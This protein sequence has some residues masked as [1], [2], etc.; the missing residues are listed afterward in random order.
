M[1]FADI[2]NLLLGVAWTLFGVAS[3]PK[4]RP[5]QPPSYPLAVRNPYLSTWMPGNH[6]A[7]LPS[8]SP[9]FWAGQDL[10]WGIIVRV[11]GVAYNVFGVPKGVKGTKAGVIKGATYTSTHSIFELTAGAVNVKLDFFSPVSPSNY[12]RQSL[13]FSKSLISSSKN[14]LI[15]FQVI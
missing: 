3:G 7:H 6:V 10:T 1:N 4:Y 8:S 12:L 5:I 13:P 15:I 9:Q 14:L 11:D 2:Q